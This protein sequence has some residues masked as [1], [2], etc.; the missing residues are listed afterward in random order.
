MKHIGVFTSGGDSPGM[1]AALRAVVRA[2]LYHNVQIS[3]IYRGYE[4]I[5]D[6]DIVQFDARSVAHIIDKGGTKIKTARSQE[7]RT[8]EGR[9]VAFKNLQKHNSGNLWRWYYYWRTH[10]L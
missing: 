6:N 3:A 7:F 9:S 8:K 10:F 4:G 1:N 2:A 5:I